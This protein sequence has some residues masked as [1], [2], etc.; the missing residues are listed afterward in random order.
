MLGL[1]PRHTLIAEHGHDLVAVLAGPGPAGVLLIDQAQALLDLLA[2]RD[3]DIDDDLHARIVSATTVAVTQL[4][5]ASWR[6]LA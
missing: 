3:A 2:S 6:L 4:V 5:S 1:G